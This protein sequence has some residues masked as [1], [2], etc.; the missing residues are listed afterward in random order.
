MDSGSLIEMP[1]GD[2]SATGKFSGN[3]KRLAIS[4]TS[5]PTMFIADGYGGGGSLEAE[6]AAPIPMNKLAD[7]N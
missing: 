6:V 1:H 4:F 3:S 2:L 7:K 5:L